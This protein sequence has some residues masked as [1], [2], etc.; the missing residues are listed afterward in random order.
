MNESRQKEWSEYSP[1][2]LDYA[3]MNEKGEVEYRFRHGIN[4]PPNEEDDGFTES[5]SGVQWQY[6]AGKIPCR[7]LI[8]LL[9]K[10]GTE[11]YIKNEETKG[12]L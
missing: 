12:D 6:L 3:G 10:W 1:W 2:M 7:E 4:I 5:I 8:D 11:Q 9:I